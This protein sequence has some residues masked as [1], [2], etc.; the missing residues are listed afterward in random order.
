MRTM[1]RLK[2]DTTVKTNP[3]MRFVVPNE[4][5][6]AN[7]QLVIVDVVLG[8]V[9][10]VCDKGAEILHNSSSHFSSIYQDFS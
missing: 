1:L 4:T 8:Q 6:P 9:K 2:L 7:R 10:D 5:I 3:I